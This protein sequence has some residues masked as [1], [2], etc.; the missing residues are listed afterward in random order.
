MCS[1]LTS[2]F[3]EPLLCAKL[4]FYFSLSSYSFGHINGTFF[5]VK[6]L[7]PISTN[8][9]CSVEFMLFTMYSWTAV[10][11]SWTCHLLVETVRYKTRN[12]RRSYIYIPLSCKPD[13]WFSV[14]WFLC[15]PLLLLECITLRG[16]GS[17]KCNQLKR[18]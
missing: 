14:Q 3:E 12:C 6:F 10:G 5:K 18:L 17:R 2:S 9:G 8:N 16:S 11:F 7:V 13:W 4:A 15:Y 1:I